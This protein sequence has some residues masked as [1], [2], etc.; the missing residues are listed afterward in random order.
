M[1]NTDRTRYMPHV[2]GVPSGAISISASPCSPLH[3]HAEGWGWV[4][5]AIEEGRWR[6]LRDPLG[7]LLQVQPMQDRQEG[8]NMASGR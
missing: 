6:R 7:P 8:N 1:S 2:P 5:G 3:A 4:G